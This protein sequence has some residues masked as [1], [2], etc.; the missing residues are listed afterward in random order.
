M[1][2][3]QTCALP[4]LKVAGGTNRIKQLVRR[5]RIDEIFIIIP[6]MTDERRAEI[7]EE[8]GKTGY[9]TVIL[10][11]LEDLIYSKNRCRIAHPDVNKLLNRSPIKSDQRLQASY[12]EGKIIS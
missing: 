1:T 7:A 12:I 2:G 10:S 9:K 3:V 4:I 6:D 5:Y 8:C 11:R